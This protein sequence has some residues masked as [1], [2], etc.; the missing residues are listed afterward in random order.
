MVAAVAGGRRPSAPLPKRRW[1]GTPAAAP[2]PPQPK[3]WWQG[4]RPAPQPNP[5]PRQAA[6]KSKP[7]AAKAAAT[8]PWEEGEWELFTGC[9]QLTGV[10]F[11]LVVLELVFSGHW[12]DAYPFGVGVMIFGYESVRVGHPQQVLSCPEQEGPHTATHHLAVRPSFSASG[13]MYA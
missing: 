9:L 4:G 11:V 10:S 2:E 8:R 13:P 1:H 6:L 12:Y 5:L 3:K 7:E